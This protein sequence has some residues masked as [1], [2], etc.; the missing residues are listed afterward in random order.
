MVL[1]G[2]LGTGAGA[3][4]AAPAGERAWAGC[5]YGEICVYSGLNGT[6]TRCDWYGDDSNWASGAETCSIRVKSIWNNG[7]PEAYRHVNFFFKAGHDDFYACARHGWRG[8][9]GPTNGVKLLSHG[10][11]T[12]CRTN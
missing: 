1:T 6:G 9:T 3:A 8:N 12:A 5:D 2:V 7:K 10:W 11:A 4:G